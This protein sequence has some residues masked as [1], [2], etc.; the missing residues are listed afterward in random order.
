MLYL[1]SD[2]AKET[3]RF[4]AEIT[5]CPDCEAIVDPRQSRDS[6]KGYLINRSNVQLA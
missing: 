2:K 5:S 3:E 6:R 4:L 1:R